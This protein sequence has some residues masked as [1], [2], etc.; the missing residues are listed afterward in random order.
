M[1]ITT[2]NV[3]NRVSTLLQDTTYVRWP[4]AELLDYL[5]DGQREIAI[6]KPSASLATAG[7]QLAAGSKQSIPSGGLVLID[8]VCNIASSAPGAARFRS[9]RIVAREV[10]DAQVPDWHSTGLAQGE[11]IKHYVYSALDP[12]TFWVYPS[13]TDTSRYVEIVYGK[14]PTD[15]VWGGAIQLDDI[16]TPALVNYICYRAYSKDAEYAANAAAATSYYQA[17]M[18]QMT[19]KTA[20]EQTYN[21]NISMGNFN[22]NI[23]GMK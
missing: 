21:P 6:Y 2:T 3:I 11:Y 15:A 13:P 4:T 19:G 20:S 1:A 23:P 17:F 18:G 12:K 5:N 7:V 14:T 22:P 10:L 9:I 16:W 8:V